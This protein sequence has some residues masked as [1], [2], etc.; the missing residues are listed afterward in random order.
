[1]EWTPQLAVDTDTRVRRELTHSRAELVQFVAEGGW[2]LLPNAPTTAASYVQDAAGVKRSEAYRIVA[3]ARVAMIIL[4]RVQQ[5]DD[6]IP[7]EA[8]RWILKDVLRSTHHGEYLCSIT[9]E[10]LADIEMRCQAGSDPYA[11]IKESVDAHPRPTGDEKDQAQTDTPEDGAP[12]STTTPRTRST[13]DSHEE[14]GGD[15]QPRYPDPASIEKAERII[16][17]PHCRTPLR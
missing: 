7:L 2:R 15:D 16:I 10:V 14:T 11:A 13:D 9:G 1:M 5:G 17:C 3:T 4:T 8:Y 12:D 6:P